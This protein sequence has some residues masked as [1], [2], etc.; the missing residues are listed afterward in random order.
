M[1]A[2]NLTSM[3][4]SRVTAHWLG[5]AGQSLPTN[6]RS[7]PIAQTVRMTIESKAT[8]TCSTASRPRLRLPCI[9]A[10]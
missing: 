3:L 8:K 7:K 1:R 6:M 5:R 2:V 10:L 4:L 9:I